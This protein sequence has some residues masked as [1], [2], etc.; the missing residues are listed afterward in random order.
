MLGVERGGG[1]KI[2]SNEGRVIKG[3]GRE[4]ET[5]MGREGERERKRSGA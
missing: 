1:V 5:E 3:T 4:T 2:V